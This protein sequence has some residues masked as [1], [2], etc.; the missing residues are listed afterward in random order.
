MGAP[1][2][3]SIDTFEPSLIRPVNRPGHVVKVSHNVG[4]KVA[5]D[6]LDA[7][8]WAC[9]H[10]QTP[11]EPTNHILRDDDPPPFAVSHRGEARLT[12]APIA[13]YSIN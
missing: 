2:L 12:V 3:V 5:V 6:V 13:V 1:N 11:I 10:D 7:D 9:L 8:R 4:G